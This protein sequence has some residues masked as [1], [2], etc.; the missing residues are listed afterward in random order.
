MANPLSSCDVTVVCDRPAISPRRD[1]MR[2]RLADILSLGIDRI[3][4]KAT[5]PEGLGLAGDGIGCLAIAT[6][7]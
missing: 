1:E 7:A 2:A 6:I 5:R 3:S 4:V